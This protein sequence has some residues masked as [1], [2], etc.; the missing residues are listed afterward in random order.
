[1]GCGLEV[2]ALCVRYLASFPRKKVIAAAIC[3]CFLLSYVE[4]STQSL[5]SRGFP[6]DSL[7]FLKNLQAHYWPDWAE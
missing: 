3:S 5:F 4:Y 6:R 1:M 7:S 2:C